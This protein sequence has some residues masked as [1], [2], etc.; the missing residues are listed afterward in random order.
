MEEEEGNK[1]EKAREAWQK[2]NTFVKDNWGSWSGLNGWILG[3]F[4]KHPST[5]PK[6]IDE[7]RNHVRSQNWQ[8]THAWKSRKTASID[9]LIEGTAKI[10][11]QFLKAKTSGDAGDWVAARYAVVYG[12]MLEDMAAELKKRAGD[13]QAD[14]PKEGKADGLKINPLLIG[15]LIALKFLT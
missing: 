3:I 5:D 6:K 4:G 8:I 14:K 13:K 15:G 1:F 7:T 9:A 2:L 10:Q 12:E 11:R